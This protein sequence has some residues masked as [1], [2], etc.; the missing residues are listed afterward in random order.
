MVQSLRKPPQ[1][2]KAD[3]EEVLDGLAEITTYEGKGFTVNLP[4]IFR[5]L[6]KLFEE[7]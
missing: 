3:E 2:T 5:R 7:D 4:E 1:Q 6:K